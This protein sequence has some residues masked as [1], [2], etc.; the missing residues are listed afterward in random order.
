MLR[1]VASEMGDA[2]A[3]SSTPTPVS[4][5]AAAA[6]PTVVPSTPVVPST[7]PSTP[8]GIFGSDE[9]QKE[10]PVVKPVAP[11]APVAPVV[12]VKPAAVPTIVNPAQVTLSPEA[13]AALRAPAPITPVAATAFTPE[14]QAEFDRSFNIVRLTPE[15]FKSITGYLPEGESLKAMEAFGHDIAKQAVS[16]ALYQANLLFKEKETALRETLA[17][18]MNSHQSQRATEITSYFNA[19]HPDLKD[20]TALIQDITALEKAK[21]TKFASVEEA[22]TFVANRARELLKLPPVSG[23]VNPTSGQIPPV[24]K[25]T[26]PTTMVGGR[27]GN[28]SSSQPPV[29]GPRAV[30]GTTSDT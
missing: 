7:V 22:S 14:E 15:R 18:L 27:P 17:P 2:G 30:F 6:A 20:H 29:S 26:M 24:Q 19:T 13:L 16:L 5:P 4:T 1:D 25:Q 10:V 3:A 28:P 21:G 9:E 23:T 12:P 11:V 8:K